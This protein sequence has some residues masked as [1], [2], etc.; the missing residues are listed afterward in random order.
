MDV[1][2]HLDLFLIGCSSC[3]RCC[4]LRISC[5]VST[6]LSRALA[7]QTLFTRGQ[8][9]APRVPPRSSSSRASKNP[10][11]FDMTLVRVS[12]RSR[13][14]HHPLLTRLGDRRGSSRVPW[15]ASD[16]VQYHRHIVRIFISII[17]H[18]ICEFMC[19]IHAYVFHCRTVRKSGIYVR[20]SVVYV[21]IRVG[22]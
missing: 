15:Q 19:N 22:K 8:H 17:F 12:H 3:P 18:D 2:F 7:L 16:F 21:R 1:R 13:R 5:E 4:A 10:R 6:M 14:P 11:T 20:T 9:N